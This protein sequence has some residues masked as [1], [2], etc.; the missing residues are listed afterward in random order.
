[1]KKLRINQ[2]KD[3]ASFSLLA[4]LSMKPVSR[5][6]NIILVIELRTLL[7][8]CVNQCQGFHRPVSVQFLVMDPQ[9]FSQ[10]ASHLYIIHYLTQH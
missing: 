1:M 4:L 2:K 10:E 7:Q 3:K 8:L 5:A 6:C 9:L